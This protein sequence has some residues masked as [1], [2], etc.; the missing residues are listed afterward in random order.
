MANKNFCM[1]EWEQHTGVDFVYAIAFDL[2]MARLEELYPGNHKNQAYQDIRTILRRRGFQNQQGTLYY[3]N[4]ET[5]HIDVVRAVRE[6]QE[7]HPWFR[8]SLNDIRVLQILKEPD[9]LK[10]YMDL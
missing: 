6:V 2:D 7:K 10:E 9:D 1:N 4:N 5:K 3:G 8:G